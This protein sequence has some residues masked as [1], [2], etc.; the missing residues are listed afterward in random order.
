MTTHTIEAGRADARYWG[1]LWEYRELALFL[2]WRDVAVRY[3]QTVVGVAWALLQPALTMAVFTVVFGRLAR[4]PSGG[5]PYPVLV[6]AGL[7]P[8]QFFARALADSSASL[9]GN[10]NL[11]TKVYFPRLLIPV[12][13][14]AAGFVDFL[15]S[16]AILVVV[17]LWYGM[18]LVGLLALPL[19]M[20]FA[21][22]IALGPALWIAALNVR[23][24]D[25]RYIIPFLLQFGIYISPV[26]FLTE[27]V[28]ERWRVL[29]ALNPMVGVI[30]GFRWSVSG[31]TLPIDGRVLAISSAVSLV[32][33]V[34]GFRYFRKTEKGFADVI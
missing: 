1:D 23:Y 7:L 15:V 3:K 30:D 5:V 11:I 32:L 34:S 25:F 24:R 10:S 20:V 2:A 28:P 16:L 19:W 29:Y 22:V 17:M 6:L 12:S 13:T 14:I 8:W 21:A 31:G 18:P 26:G 27:I 9:V 4:L 33:L